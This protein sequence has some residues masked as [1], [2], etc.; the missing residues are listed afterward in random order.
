MNFDNVLSHNKS[1][2]DI[3]KNKS[4]LQT[5]KS[6]SVINSISDYRTHLDPLK[7]I[8]MSS[9]IKK[10]NPLLQTKYINNY[11]EDDF[12]DSIPKITN[13][14]RY[15]HVM[16]EIYLKRKIKGIDIVRIVIQFMDFVEYIAAGDGFSIILTNNKIAY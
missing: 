5:Q 7:R 15:Y 8:S 6:K 16:T 1:K 2:S 10:R 12:E 13:G 11:F 3:I 9:S 14:N 4:M